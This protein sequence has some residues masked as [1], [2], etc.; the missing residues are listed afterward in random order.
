[1]SLRFLGDVVRGL[2]I[3]M[4]IVG[5]IL[6]LSFLQPRNRMAKLRGRTASCL[7]GTLSVTGLFVFVFGRALAYQ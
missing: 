7:L 6:S 5:A 3:T 2:G 4:H 1:M